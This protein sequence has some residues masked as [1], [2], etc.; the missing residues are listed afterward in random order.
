M[1]ASVGGVEI[2]ISR[3]FPGEPSL[4]SI[5]A[6]LLTP[7]IE[8]ICRRQNIDTADI[9]S[10][11]WPIFG[12]SRYATAK[13]LVLRSDLFRLLM[14][15]ENNWQALEPDAS[16]NRTHPF[17]IWFKSGKIPPPLT[18]STCFNRMWLAN[19]TP[20]AVTASGIVL[21]KPITDENGDPVIDPATGEQQV[22]VTN[23]GEALYILTFHDSRWLHRGTRLNEVAMDGWEKTIAPRSWRNDL[24]LQNF[25][26][27][28]VKRSPKSIVQYAVTT[29]LGMQDAEPSRGLFN[30]G[31]GSG[32]VDYYSTIYNSYS[33]D[34]DISPSEE[35]FTGFPGMD[36][37]TSRPLLEF[38]DYLMTKCNVAMHV[39]PRGLEEPVGRY[40]FTALGYRRPT[41]E[42]PDYTN[43]PFR[44]YMERYGDDLIAGSVF[45][46][47]SSFVTGGSPSQGQNFKW[48]NRI[49]SYAPFEETSKEQVDV[50]VRRANIPDGRPPDVFKVDH[51]NREA[52]GP[53]TSKYLPEPFSQN[54]SGIYNGFYSDYA[55]NRSLSSIFADE[56]LT[57]AQTSAIQEKVNRLKDLFYDLAS[58]SLIPPTP[59][60]TSRDFEEIGG[61]Y[62]NSVDKRR[63]HEVCDLW[64]RGWIEVPPPEETWMGAAWIEYR[65]QTDSNGFGFPTTRI[66]SDYYDPLF[67]PQADDRP[68]EV[69]TSGLAKSWRDAR[70]KNHISVDW[71]FGIPCLIKITGNTGP[72]NA[73]VK[74]W[75]YR[76]KLI[77][78]G[79]VFDNSS[80]HYPPPQSNPLATWPG[81][82]KDFSKLDTTWADQTILAY[83]LA[84]LANTST[85]AGPG[86]K[87]PL[88]Q[89]GFDILPIG[90]DR[91]GEQ[92]E[93]IVQAT[94]YMSVRFENTEDV[95]RAADTPVAYFC[96][97]NA[98]DGDCPTPLTDNTYDGGVY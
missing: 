60:L 8:A 59:K 84:E 71:P 80:G 86:Y 94:L 5:Y 32:N 2:E 33:Q 3:E 89:S 44:E 73:G 23:E 14:K 46:Q 21:Q 81:Q 75:S 49:I 47:M 54:I 9:N 52:S 41:S 10:L 34:Y 18:E 78:K 88:A 70:G 22:L 67:V 57:F 38:C 92:H 53:L 97:T 20:L 29:Q 51:Y 91:L 36:S 87:L 95:D 26:A 64:F 50:V 6:R 65:L 48:V 77:Y 19:I 4:R 72:F 79:M 96:L 45:G 56:P 35:W 1:S 61:Y 82:L 63:L 40:Q 85:F 93:V 66:Y 68:L 74:A 42:N 62:M 31:S 7:E 90:L 24:V 37:I 39:R 17:R 28:N 69:S 43:Y 83:N 55:G 16:N 11:K 25:D 15:E 58:P 30:F 13:I 98:I 76:A 27:A 12:L